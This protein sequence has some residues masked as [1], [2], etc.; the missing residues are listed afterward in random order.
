MHC[1]GAVA[2]VSHEEGAVEA[3][4][5]ERVLILLDGVEDIWGRDDADLIAPA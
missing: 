1:E 2:L 3:L 4:N 5:P